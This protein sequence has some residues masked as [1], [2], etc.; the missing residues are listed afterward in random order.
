MIRED[1]SDP[2]MVRMH[3]A[4]M[5][6]RRQTRV[7]MDDVDTLPQSDGS[8]VWKERKE[9]R[10]GCRGSYCR[11]RYVV[12]LETGRQPS[13][14]NSVWRVT[15]AYDDDLCQGDEDRINWVR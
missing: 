5:G 13:Y 6:E 12:H 9:I 11:E 7:A 1:C 10:Q 4:L 14:T 3:Y 8:Q 15:V 2:H